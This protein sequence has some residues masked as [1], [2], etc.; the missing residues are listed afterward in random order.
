MCPFSYYVNETVGLPWTFCFSWLVLESENEVL[1]HCCQVEAEVQVPQLASVNTRVGR[2]LVIAGGFGVPAP[3]VVPVDPV[4]G[5]ASLC[6]TVDKV[7]ALH[8]PSSD[9]RPAG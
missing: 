9:T 4:M 5:V 3:P 6:W 7:L 1:P 2:L 8:S